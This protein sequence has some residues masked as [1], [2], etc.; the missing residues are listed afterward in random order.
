MQNLL[1][2]QIFGLQKVGLNLFKELNSLFYWI[3][4]EEKVEQ[5]DILETVRGIPSQQKAIKEEENKIKEKEQ[6]K[7]I[8]QQVWN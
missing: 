8:A 3:D 1:K 2:M 6:Q 5:T 7:P 4:I